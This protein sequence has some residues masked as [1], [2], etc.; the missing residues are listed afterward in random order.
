MK[1]ATLALLTAAAIISHRPAAEAEDS[2][3]VQLSEHLKAF[4]RVLGTWELSDEDEK[5]AKVTMRWVF[6][7][8]AGGNA[9]TGVRSGARSASSIFYYDPELRKVV[10]VSVLDSGHIIK[11]IYT[12]EML[13]KD[14]YS[15]LSYLTT[16]DG[17]QGTSVEH[18]RWIGKDQLAWSRTDIC[19]EGEKRRPG[20]PETVMNRVK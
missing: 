8:A 2:P 6:Q 20:G 13:D 12:K 15:A 10:C 4:E 7:A 9:I 3:K 18:I 5:G 14:T 16:P 19:I 1:H 11:T 17:K